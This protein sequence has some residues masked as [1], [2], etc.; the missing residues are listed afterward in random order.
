MTITDRTRPDSPAT[1]VLEFS[2]LGQ[3]VRRATGARE[4]RWTHDADGLR[5]SVQSPDGST[6]RYEHDATGR[7]V[8]VDHSAFGEVRYEHDAAGRLLQ[9][10]AGD[11]LQTW[12]Y[13][14][15]HVVRHARIDADGTNASTIERDADGRITRVDGPG[16]STTYEHDDAAQLVASVQEARRTDWVYDVAG[17]LAEE[18]TD[19][20]ARRFSTTPP[21]S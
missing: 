3:L 19:S 20:G 10:R 15:G 14:N 6:T 21:D 4:I 18:R 8:R 7:V 2:R 12:E 13:A 16:G 9:A 5:T 11:Q 1:H 17:R